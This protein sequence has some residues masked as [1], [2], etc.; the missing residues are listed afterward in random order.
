MKQYDILICDANK[1][2]R[3]EMSEFF[4]KSNFSIKETDSA[5]Y[6]IASVLK[7]YSSLIILGETFD[8]KIPVSHVIALLKRSNKAIK[9]ILIS[10]ESSLEELQKIRQNGIFYHSLTP[11]SKKDQE[12]LLT[13]VEF[14]TS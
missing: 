12:E 6:V 13:V 4:R 8:E 5:A 9:I 1:K 11:T 2:I 14:A 10:D 3:S 7:G